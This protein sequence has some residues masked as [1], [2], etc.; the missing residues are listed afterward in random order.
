MKL[1]KV[2][3]ITVALLLL[4]AA[5]YIFAFDA[6]ETEPKQPTAQTQTNNQPVEPE[7]FDKTRAV[8]GGSSTNSAPCQMAMSHRIC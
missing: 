6:N 1:A 4:G 2:L 7:G 5:A 8:R 3:L